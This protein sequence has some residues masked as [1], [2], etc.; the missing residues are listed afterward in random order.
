M[1]IR[2]ML[3][4]AIVEIESAANYL[5]GMSLDRRIPK[6]TRSSILLIVQR[7]DRISEELIENSEGAQ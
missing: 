3:D 5:R 2:E 1:N 4:D 6:D 7:L